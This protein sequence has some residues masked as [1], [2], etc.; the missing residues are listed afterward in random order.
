MCC[1]KASSKCC[2]EGL[3]TW[4]VKQAPAYMHYVQAAR[5]ARRRPPRAAGAQQSRMRT[6]TRLRRTSSGSARRPIPAPCSATGVDA[7]PTILA[8]RTKARVLSAAVHGAPQPAGVA[9]GAAAQGAVSAGGRAG[10]A[11]P[12]QEPAPQRASALRSARLP[13]HQP[14]SPLLPRP[15][16]RHSSNCPQL[17]CKRLAGAAAEA[18]EAARVCAVGQLKGAA[19]VHAAPHAGAAAGTSACRGAHHFHGR[20][21]CCQILACQTCHDA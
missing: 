8:H 3:A 9:E 1:V 11:G 12:L 17:T 4:L 5:S 6:R 20:G 16:P 21:C 2:A 7:L 18:H 14:P 19:G 13:F 10:A 15:S